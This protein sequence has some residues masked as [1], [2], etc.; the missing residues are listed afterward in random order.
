MG[1]TK[2][3]VMAAVAAGAAA[4]T[5]LLGA[6][7]AG[8]SGHPKAGEPGAAG[9]CGSA[10]TRLRNPAEWRHEVFL[11]QPAGVGTPWTGGSCGDSSRPVAFLAHGYLGSILEGYQGLVDH[12]VSNGFIVVFPG[13]DAEFDPPHQ[14][15]AVLQGFVTGVAA[16]GRADTTRVGVIGHSFGG[17][18]TPWLLQ[19]VAARGWGATALWSTIF[20]P[21]FA[22]AVGTGDIPVPA[23]THLTMVNYAEDF[24][25]DARIGNEIYGAIVGPDHRRL[26]AGRTHHVMLR[27]DRSVTPPLVADHIGPVSVEV[28]AGL[29]TI[30]VDQYDVWST[31]RTIDATSRCSLQATWCTTDLTYTGTWADGHAVTPAVVDDHMADMG[32]PAV[33]ECNFFLNPRHCP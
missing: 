4:A 24:V 15:A 13:Y 6:C 2:R 10:T 20:A 33:Q 19:Q 32:P 29:G 27:S 25:V 16:S 8:P 9:P 7:T 28:I 12:L 30:G 23:N 11:I 22:F 5:L 17:G 14:Y 26:P 1:F 3:R 21:H 31:F 18:M